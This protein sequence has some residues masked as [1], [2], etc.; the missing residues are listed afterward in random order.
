MSK[1]LGFADDSDSEE[2]VFFRN[3]NPSINDSSLT[4]K[5]SS[6]DDGDLNEDQDSDDS[7]GSLRSFDSFVRRS[8]R[9]GASSEFAIQIEEGVQNQHLVSGVTHHYAP[10]RG[11][12]APVLA[13]LEQVPSVAPSSG[14]H[15]NQ[16]AGTSYQQSAV[17]RRRLRKKD[18]E[19]R[20]QEILT[21]NGDFYQQ[22]GEMETNS[23]ATTTNNLVTLDRKTVSSPSSALNQT[24]TS[25]NN[26]ILPRTS[27]EKQRVVFGPNSRRMISPVR[28]K[29]TRQQQQKQQHNDNMPP[30]F[31]REEPLFVYPQKPAL[32]Y[33]H[34]PLYTSYGILPPGG[35]INPNNGRVRFPRQQTKRPQM[36]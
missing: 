25:R 1:F 32:F 21:E 30:V 17:A 19:K 4:R 28:T 22:H 14:S 9:C 11:E 18:A 36:S 2:I 10:R 33:Q 15:S 20:S 16:S 6:F 13:P 7:A 8:L 35:R 31:M 26:N 27:K 29:K 12:S 24:S 23:Q 5:S 34:Y 3:A